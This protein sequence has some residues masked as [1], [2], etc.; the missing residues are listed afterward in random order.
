METDGGGPSR[1]PTAAPPPAPAALPAPSRD[2]LA[3]L[4]WTKTWTGA[5]AHPDVEAAFWAASNPALARTD[6]L[7][8]ALFAVAAAVSAVLYPPHVILLITSA[9]STALSA[10][11]LA[12]PR[13]AAGLR[14]RAAPAARAAFQA[15]LAFNTEYRAA[16]GVHMLPPPGRR[17]HAPSAALYM[18]KSPRA[19]ALAV[20]GVGFILPPTPYVLGTLASLIV[21]A[22]SFGNAAREKERYVGRAAGERLAAGAAAATRA[23]GLAGPAIPAEL[24]T[25]ATMVVNG[26]S[27]ACSRRA[28]RTRRS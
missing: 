26:S 4:P 1:R 9:A 27:W 21:C 2:C 25:E 17:A 8:F 24:A 11:C 14:T 20:T 18:A 5:F 19:H 28:S 6:G 23:L 7:V 3:G 12:S 22:S 10:L 15:V 16:V 13:R